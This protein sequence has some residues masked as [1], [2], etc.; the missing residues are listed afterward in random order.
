MTKRSRR[1]K[2][3]A[4]VWAALIGLLGVLITAIL[5]SPVLLEF[6]KDKSTPVNTEISNP[7]IEASQSK[8]VSTV[9]TAASLGN[10]STDVLS[11]AAFCI[12]AETGEGTPA[13]VVA[14]SLVYSST[15][16]GRIKELPLVGGQ[17]I[18]L[19]NI[20]ILDAVGIYDTGAVKVS[21]VLDSGETVTD[22]VDF[23]Q[24]DGTKLAGSTSFGLFELRFLDLKHM[25]FH[26]DGSCE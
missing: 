21:I 17:K 14:N 26:E 7:V 2:L 23:S 18:S 20:K 16:L 13:K 19:M 4:E 24:Y 10:D 3:P 22:V 9:Q 1:R 8:Q 6:I 25:E 5:S 12:S 11:Q 15:A